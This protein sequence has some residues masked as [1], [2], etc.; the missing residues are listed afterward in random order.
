MYITESQVAELLSVKDCIEVLRNLFMQHFVNIPRYRLKSQNSL[1]HVMSASV[2]ALGVMGLK[3]YGT[4]KSGASFA[5]LLF[6]EKTG[7]LIAVLEADNLGQIRTGAASGLA[8][9]LLANKDVR[10]GA[11]IGTGYQA[12]TQLL[13][14]DAVRRFS[15]I[16]VYSRSQENRKSF[17]ARMQGKVRRS[18]KLVDSPSAET[19]AREA[20]VICVITSSRE[21]VLFGSWL[22]AGCHINAAGVNWSNKR[23]IDQQ[24]VRNASL[25]VADSREQS[26]IEAGDLTYVL[27]ELEWEN[28]AE[29][30]D[31]VK[32][33]VGRRSPQDI[34][35]FKSNGIAAEDVAAAHFVVR[36]LDQS[37][38]RRV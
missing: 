30:T 16:R 14:I 3:A 20:D 28:V 22:K 12:E 24:C 27:S 19:A 4:S 18:V 17:I 15:E 38:E 21:P 1:L 8:T 36:K 13:A 5:V 31:L 34:T 11:I 9:D 10:V 2:P 37:G 26:R 7:S 32:G 6:D 25:I 29:L 33:R 35:L 23:E